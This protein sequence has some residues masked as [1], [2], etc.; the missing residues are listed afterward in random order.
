MYS[1]HDDSSIRVR[2]SFTLFVLES[3]IGH[4]DAVNSVFLMRTTFFTHRAL[5]E[6]SSDGI[7]LRT[8]LPFPLKMRIV[9]SQL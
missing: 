7:W 4:N 2:D 6:Q 8:M 1:G 5:M 9:P 3:Y